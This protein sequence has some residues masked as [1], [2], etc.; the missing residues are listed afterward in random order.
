MP[1]PETEKEVGRFSFLRNLGGSL[2]QTTEDL[3]HPVLAQQWNP[4][5]Y[6][7]P[8]STPTSWEMWTMSLLWPDLQGY[9]GGQNEDKNDNSNEKMF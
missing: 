8:C 1:T 3:G 5:G 2:L 4:K 9:H 7:T 6:H